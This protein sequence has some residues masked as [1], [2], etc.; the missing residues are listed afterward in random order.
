MKSQLYAVNLYFDPVT[1]KC[2]GFDDP[3]GSHFL[4]DKVDQRHAV[5]GKYNL[6]FVTQAACAA[7]DVTY[8]A[9]VYP[10]GKTSEELSEYAA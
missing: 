10:L 1:N 9:Q 4:D 7:C 3:S 2:V 8:Q 5:T 6:P